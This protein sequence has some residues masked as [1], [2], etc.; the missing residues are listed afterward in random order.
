MYCVASAV[1]STQ[2]LEPGWPNVSSQTG[3]TWLACAGVAAQTR[4]KGVMGEVLVLRCK[5]C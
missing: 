4:F 5:R 1:A 2:S 3:K